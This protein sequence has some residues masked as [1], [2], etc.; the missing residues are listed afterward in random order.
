[1][2]IEIYILFAIIVFIG[3]NISVGIKNKRLW[4]NEINR[5]GKI[6]MLF[7]IFL[8]SVFWVFSI[9]LLSLSF[10]KDAKLYQKV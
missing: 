5:W 7:F 1:M 2:L 3:F 10:L 4:T 8:I 6:E 9:P